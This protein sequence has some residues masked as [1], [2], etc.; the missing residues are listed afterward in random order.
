MI[1]VVVVVVTTRTIWGGGTKGEPYQL[2]SQQGQEWV[3]HSC[4]MMT[5]GLKFTG[6]VAVVN[7]KRAYFF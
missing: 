5:A 3:L 6:Q 7:Y 4:Q 1:S 2:H